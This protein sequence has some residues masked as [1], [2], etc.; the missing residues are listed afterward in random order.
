M[1]KYC[2]NCRLEVSTLEETKVA[3]NKNKAAKDGFANV[4]KSCSKMYAKKHNLEHGNEMK[5]LIQ[6]MYRNQR[7]NSKT[8]GDEAPNYTSRELIHWLYDNNFVGLYKEWK[9]SGYDKKLVPSCDRL[10]DYKSYTLDNIQLTNWET[11]SKLSYRDRLKGVNN[12]ASIAVDQ[13]SL[14]GKFIK[15]YWSMAK[16]ERDHGISS[17]TI[18]YIVKKNGMNKTGFLWKLG[19]IINKNRKDLIAEGNKDEQ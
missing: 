18:S 15:H 2:S 4:C 16:A 9:K 3:F 7:F 17:G 8:R 19:E 11:N 5:N 12:K 13:F 1:T 6:R 10:D 14:E